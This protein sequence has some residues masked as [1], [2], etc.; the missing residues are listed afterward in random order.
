MC[1]WIEQ[2]TR[3][4]SV[5]ECAILSPGARSK[6]VFIGVFLEVFVQ[7]RRATGYILG[8]TVTVDR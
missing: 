4:S 7:V 8:W 3:S 1:V 6:G 5:V 2:G